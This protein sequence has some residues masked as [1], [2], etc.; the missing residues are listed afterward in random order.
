MRDL[1]KHFYEELRRHNYVTPTSYLTLL[2][3][4]NKLLKDQ[5]QKLN[6]D[7]SRYDNGITKLVNTN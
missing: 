3:A 4:F 5:T 1:S 2:K 6:S 7:I